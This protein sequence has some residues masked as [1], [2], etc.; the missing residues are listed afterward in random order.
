MKKTTILAIA[1]AVLV[2]VACFFSYQY[3]QMKMAAQAAKLVAQQKQAEI[4]ELR[5]KEVAAEADAAE[6]I[7]KAAVLQQQMAQLQ[8]STAASAAELQHRL[9]VLQTAQPSALVTEAQRILGR[10]DIYWNGTQIVFSLEAFRHQCAINADWENFTLYREPNYQ[11]QIQT[12]TDLIAKLNEGLAADSQAI[13]F[14]KMQIT[15]Q[16]AIQAAL[17]KELAARSTESFFA[18]LTY[19]IVGWAAGFAYSEIRK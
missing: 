9:T 7:R 6:A 1:V 10:T 14:L 17:R 16:E 11:S 19:G 2:I 4:T 13:S 8:A 12:Q 3:A 18:K 15:A 5:K